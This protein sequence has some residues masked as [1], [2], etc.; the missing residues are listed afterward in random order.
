MQPRNSRPHRKKRHLELHLIARI[1][2]LLTRFTENYVPSS[3]SIACILTLITFAA[4]T[5]LA[6]QSLYSCLRHWGEGF[7]LL[8]NFA[9]QMCLMLVTGYMVAVS[10][11]VNKVL[12]RLSRVPRTSRQ[13]IVTMATSSM[14]FAW[15]HW[16]LGLVVSS[17]FLRHLVRRHP[18]VDYRVLVTV[19]YFGLGTTWHA[20]LSASAP[21]LSATPGHFLEHRLGIVPLTETVFTAF[22][23]SLAAVVVVAL[24][25]LSALLQ[26][27]REEDRFLIPAG[28]LSETEVF[29]VRQAPRRKSFATRID[30]GYGVNL[31]L[32][33]TGTAWLLSHFATSSFHEI[34]INT[35]NFFFFMAAVLLHP[36]PAS[37]GKAA[38]GGG[39]LYSRYHHPVSPICG[40]LRDH[41][42]H[43]AL[44]NYRPVVCLRRQP[45]DLSGNRLLVFRPDQLFYSFRG[46]QV[47]HGSAV[48][49]FGG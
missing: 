12:T 18:R 1:A 13:A 47:D 10:P 8:L 19:A 43:S 49:D 23:L 28:L 25:S 20:G 48:P 17:L 27:T 7:W 35:I 26:P 30:Y 38:E 46:K 21:L 40:D 41:P 29:Q 42:G 3:F 22:N 15:I 39:P 6:D 33:L 5:L 36:N 16:G 4:G 32:G 37:L 2:V 34:S 44:R 9:M 31:I 11:W 14:I 24:A 45:R